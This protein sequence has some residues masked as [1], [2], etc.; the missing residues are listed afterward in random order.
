MGKHATLAESS[1]ARTPLR[2][3]KPTCRAGVSLLC[4]LSVTAR[5]VHCWPKGLRSAILAASQRKFHAT[6]AGKRKVASNQ[7]QASN[8]LLYS[9][10]SSASL[11]SV[12]E[13]HS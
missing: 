2:T 13:P 8:D 5:I 7:P 6:T 10:G 11:R 9:H 12:F 1:T 3:R 4:S